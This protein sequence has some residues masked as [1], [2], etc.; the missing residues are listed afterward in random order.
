[1]S[2]REKE[3]RPGNPRRGTPH[4]KYAERSGHTLSGKHT[5]KILTICMTDDMISGINRLV[6]RKEFAN[7]S[8]AVRYMLK[9]FLLDHGV[10]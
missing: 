10:L 1:M 9:S 6:E 3:S 8:E 4:R 7:F 5:M 2:F